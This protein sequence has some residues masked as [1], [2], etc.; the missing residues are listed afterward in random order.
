MSATPIAAPPAPPPASTAPSARRRW[1]GRAATFG[2]RALVPVALLGL[3]QLLAA[4]GQIDVQLFSSPTR[5]ANALW[6]LT[7]DGTLPRNL[8]VSIRRAALGLFFGVSAALVLGVVTGLWT[9]GEEL[10]DSTIQMVRTV[11][12]FALTSVFV[13]WFGFGEV[14]KVLIVAI[15]CF[16]PVYINVFAGIRGVDRGL[17]EM[18]GA[19]G[20]SR[21]EVIRHVLL[22]GAMPQ[23]LVG[24][25]FSFSISVLALVIAETLNATTGLGYLLTTAQQYVDTDVIFSCVIVYCMLGIAVDVIVRLLERRLLAWRA[26]FDGR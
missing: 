3:W 8:L 26:G 16:F 2:R 9:L 12:V 20:K 14:P 1:R 13:V 11:P 18:A 22:P 23:T 4:T 21:W 5:T 10:I 19:M 24:L 15:A 6:E 7:L 25:R 17:L